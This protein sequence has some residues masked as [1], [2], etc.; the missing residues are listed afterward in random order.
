M[1]PLVSVADVR[2]F[3]KDKILHNLL[4]VVRP[5]VASCEKR[6][7]ASTHYTAWMSTALFPLYAVVPQPH[8]LTFS[9]DVFTGPLLENRACPVSHM[10]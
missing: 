9:E 2:A 7:P 3:V 4:F 6:E 5:H 1:T 8:D 10:L